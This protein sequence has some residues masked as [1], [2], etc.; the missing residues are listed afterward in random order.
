MI[1]GLI[2]QKWNLIE[3]HELMEP[4]YIVAS[5]YAYSRFDAIRFFHELNIDIDEFEIVPEK[6]PLTIKGLAG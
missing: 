4:N 6:Q 3:K 5:A 2:L 1:E